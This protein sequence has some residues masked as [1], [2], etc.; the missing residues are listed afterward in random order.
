MPSGKEVFTGLSTT[1]NLIGKGLIAGLAGTI[2]ITVSQMIEMH[3]SER[4]S[5]QAPMK[6]AGKV[7]G[8][9][10]KGKAK[11]ELERRN[12]NGERSEEELKQSVQENTEQFS[13]FLHLLYGTSWGMARGFLDLAGLRGLPASLAHFG[14]IWGTAQL[15]LPSANA[16]EPITRWSP[17]Q[18]VLDLGHHAVYACTAGM[19]YDAMKRQERK[20]RKK[21]NRFTF[22]TKKLW[23]SEQKKLW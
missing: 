12:S 4:G 18:I 3:L 8:V 21:N 6:V 10:P 22:L 20:K 13:Q 11:L 16:S 1:G 9:E 2:A 14:A 15:M 19:V 17:K 7:L 5:N 23:K